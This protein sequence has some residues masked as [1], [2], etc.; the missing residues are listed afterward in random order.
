MRS[1]EIGRKLAFKSFRALLTSSW[2]VQGQMSL[3]P[4]LQ[5]RYKNEAKKK[6]KK[7]YRNKGLENP[8]FRVFGTLFLPL[9]EEKEL[10]KNN[11]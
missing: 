6:K 3:F 4:L 5:S 1:F 7:N 8:S 9:M 10:E 2:T 11:E